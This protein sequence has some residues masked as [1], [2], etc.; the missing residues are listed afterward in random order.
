VVDPFDPGDGGRDTGAANSRG[1]VPTTYSA[2]A[3]S[4]R[5][6]APAG[7]RPRAE[8]ADDPL[9]FHQQTAMTVPKAERRPGAAGGTRHGNPLWPVRETLVREDVVP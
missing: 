5:T 2:V 3:E 9:D 7:A 6:H 4:I 1:E 8:R